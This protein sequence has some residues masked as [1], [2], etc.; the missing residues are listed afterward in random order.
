MEEVP[1]ATSEATSSVNGSSTDSDTEDCGSPASD[2]SERGAYDVEAW[3]W[4][5]DQTAAD[6]DTEVSGDT[7][8]SLPSSNDCSGEDTG[9]ADSPSESHSP[10]SIERESVSDDERISQAMEEFDPTVYSSRESPSDTVED[11]FLTRLLGVWLRQWW[12]QA[13]G[14]D[15]RTQTDADEDIYAEGSVG[16]TVGGEDSGGDD[17]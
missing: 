6:S 2:T 5:S 11:G 13:L 17:S 15:S 16:V 7:E 8:Q 3:T 9:P 4:E 12:R 10:P 14:R 1:P